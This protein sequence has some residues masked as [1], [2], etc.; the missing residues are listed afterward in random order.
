M[1]A[2]TEV[3]EGAG[4]LTEAPGGLFF[5]EPRPVSTEE[6][7]RHDGMKVA[8]LTNS[9]SP[10]SLPVCEHISDAVGEFRAFLSADADRYHHFPKPQASF[11]LTVQRSF[12]GLRLPRKAY[13]HWQRSELHVPY[14]TYG[15]LRAYDPDLILSV[16]L[17]LRTVLAVLYR[18]RRPQTKLILWATLSKH[19]EARR[20]WLRR[21]LRQW[22]VRHIDGAFVNGRQGEEYLRELGYCGTVNTVPYAIDEASFASHLYRPTQ[23]TFRLV[24]AGQLVPQKGLREFCTV[25]NRWCAAH[26]ATRV[27]LSLV[28]DGSSTRAIRAMRTQPNL[29]I[30]LLPTMDQTQL[31][32]HYHRADL[33]A[34]PTLG[35]EWGVVVNEAMI[36]GLPVL[37]SLYSQA[38]VE[39]VEEGVTGWV[40]D[41][42]DADDMY[43]ALERSFASTVE[44]LEAMSGRVRERIAQLSPAIVGQSAVVAMGEVWGR[45]SD[46][47]YTAEQGFSADVRP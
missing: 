26:P 20:H 11:Q 47:L 42:R 31:A 13:G 46:M 29:S 44:D 8:L 43:A 23:D 14:D 37:G 40:F 41:P 4:A 22:I 45:V 1:A 39:L 7:V 19:T 36:A 5:Q 16:Q 3:W 35:D 30:T 38:V 27:E 21:R 15:Q 18:L 33:L 2:C 24:Y 10:H 32:G 9:L 6:R 25:L 17:G 28:G 34:F 12:N